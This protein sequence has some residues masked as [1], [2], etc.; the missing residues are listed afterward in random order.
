MEIPQTIEVV[1]F[2]ECNP[3]SKKK[4][5]IEFFRSHAQSAWEPFLDKCSRY[6]KVEKIEG[7]YTELGLYPVHQ[8]VSLRHLACYAVRPTEDCA[9]LR[10][11]TQVNDDVYSWP[12]IEAG[13]EAK[14]DLDKEIEE[15]NKRLPELDSLIDLGPLHLDDEVASGKNSAQRKFVDVDN[16]SWYSKFGEAGLPLANSNVQT[17]NVLDEDDRILGDALSS[18][19]DVHGTTTLKA[20]D[21]CETMKTAMKHMREVNREKAQEERKNGVNAVGGKVSE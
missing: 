7:I 18:L 3:D 10:S 16:A 13:K 20:K 19:R 1:V 4:I 6:L 9:L 8:I 2:R 5:S 21:I 17:I 12:I 11:L 15:F 14:F